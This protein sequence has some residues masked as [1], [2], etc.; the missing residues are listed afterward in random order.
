MRGETA[1]AKSPMQG[2]HLDHPLRQTPTLRI[3]PDRGWF[4]PRSL[5]LVFTTWS[6][7]R[8][9]RLYN[10]ALMSM[11]RCGGCDLDG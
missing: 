2:P 3:P 1:T 4:S 9:H 7:R 8:R 10:R 11:S 5:G 6:D